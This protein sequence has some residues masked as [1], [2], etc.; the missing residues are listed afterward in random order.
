MNIIK[1]LI[2]VNKLSKA[3]KEA[4][5]RLDTKKGLVKEVKAVVESLK[6]DVEKLV[7]L[8]PELKSVYTEIREIIKGIL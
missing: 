2:L 1:K 4:K 6:Q 3:F 8:L 7:E 5:N